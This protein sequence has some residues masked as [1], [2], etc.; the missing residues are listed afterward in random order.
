MDCERDAI[1]QYQPGACFAEYLQFHWFSS[2]S[3]TEERKNKKSL[4]HC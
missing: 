4:I 2:L 3:K 1:V